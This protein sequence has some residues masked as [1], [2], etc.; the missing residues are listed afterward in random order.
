MA[1][2]VSLFKMDFRVAPPPHKRLK[3]LRLFMLEAI[4]NIIIGC[5]TMEV[6]GLSLLAFTHAFGRSKELK[7]AVQ[8][9]VLL[10]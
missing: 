2:F 10:E 5:C 6:V 8:S 3:L 1:F 4:N 9:L 7:Q